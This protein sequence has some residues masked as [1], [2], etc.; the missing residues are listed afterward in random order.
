MEMPTVLYT[1]AEGSNLGGHVTTVHV[2]IEELIEEMNSTLACDE[3]MIQYIIEEYN[4]EAIGRKRP[5]YEGTV[6]DFNFK[7]IVE[8]DPRLDIGGWGWSRDY[9]NSSGLNDHQYLNISVHTWN[10]TYFET[11]G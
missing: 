2:S 7:F 1:I 5:L 8:N 6:E 4:E 11:D 9:I 3:D 10:K